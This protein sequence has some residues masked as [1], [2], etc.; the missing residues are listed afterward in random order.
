MYEDSLF[1]IAKSTTGTFQPTLVLL[2]TRL[3]I[4][5]INPIYHAS[6]SAAF[7]SPRSVGIA[8]GRP[9]SSHYFFGAQGSTYFYLDPHH[10]RP[11]LHA[12]PTIEDVASCHTRRLRRI[13]VEEMDPSMLLG[14]LIRSEVDW[15]SWKKE[16]GMGPKKGRIVHIHEKEPTFDESGGTSQEREGAIDEVVSCDEDDDATVVG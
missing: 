1:A 7:A 6:L 12:Q 11:L 2:G 3:G 15:M 10:T 5:R 9:S 16:I 13:E 8:G 14:Y 4:D